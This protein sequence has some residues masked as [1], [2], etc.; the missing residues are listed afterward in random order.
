MLSKDLSTWWLELW[1]QVLVKWSSEV[2][3]T[4]QTFPISNERGLRTRTW[5]SIITS[6]FDYD[7]NSLERKKQVVTAT[8]PAVVCSK[9][10]QQEEDPDKMAI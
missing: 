2:E 6:L 9:G 4:L 7:T 1:S 3:T 8:T 5:F 10:K